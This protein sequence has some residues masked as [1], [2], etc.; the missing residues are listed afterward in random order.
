MSFFGIDAAAA[1]LASTLFVQTTIGACP[2]M[3]APKVEVHFATEPV[4][5]N[6]EHSAHALKRSMAADKESTL[7]TDKRSVVMGVTTSITGSNFNVSFRTLTDESGNQCIY[8]DKATFWISYKPAVFI[9]KEILDLPCSLKVTRE[10]EAEH[11]KIDIAAIQEYLP[12][13]QLDMMMYLRGFGYQGF[14]PYP[15][16]ELE[17]HQQRF[18][19]EIVNASKPMVEKLKQ[20]RRMRQGVIDTPENYKREAAKCPQDKPA[21]QQR[22][23]QK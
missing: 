13:I 22:F 17:K 16:G 18:M 7:A 19:Q 1:A 11:V 15:Q 23:V 10:H 4:Y 3:D 20:A 2:V 12:R 8:V 6:E 9:S 21:L 5:Y 14:G